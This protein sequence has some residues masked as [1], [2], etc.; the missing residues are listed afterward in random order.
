MRLDRRVLVTK[1]GDFLTDLYIAKGLIVML[2]EHCHFR[3][4]DRAAIAE[5]IDE[6]SAV[7][8]LAHVCYRAGDM[9]DVAA[10]TAQAHAKGALTIWDPAHSAGAVRVD[11]NEAQA[12]FAVGCGYKHPNSGPGALAFLFV[13]CQH[14]ARF[15][16]PL[17]GWMGHL[18][19]FAFEEAYW[20]CAGRGLRLLTPREHHQRGS[21]VSYAHPEAAAIMQGLIAREVIGVFHS[22]NILHFGFAPLY[23]RYVDIRDATHAPA[24]VPSERLSPA[25]LSE[26]CCARCG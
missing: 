6:D 18:Q 24:D 25:L 8:M 5:A 23:L 13:A 21:Q 7:L 16:Q 12:D 26:R 15:Q 14:Q 1:R 3:V 11:P 9:H 10:L 2:G 19:P 22:P 20:P 17:R 4:A